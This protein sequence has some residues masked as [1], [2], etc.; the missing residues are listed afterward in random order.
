MNKPETELK[1][2]DV[3]QENGQL[4]S[5]TLHKSVTDVKYK[6]NPK[7]RSCRFHT[8]FSEYPFSMK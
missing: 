1:K 3:L 8:H 2:K 7:A 6:N 4:L 5:D